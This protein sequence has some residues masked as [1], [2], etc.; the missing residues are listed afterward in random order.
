MI[1]MTNGITASQEFKKQINE[2]IM[3]VFGFSFDRWHALNLWD[4]QYER[5]SIIENGMVIAN[6]SVSKMNMT[7]NGRQRDFLQLGSVATREEYRGKGLSRKI[8]EHIIKRYPETPMF[9]LGNDSVVEFYPKFGFVPITY[10][11]PYLEHKLQNDTKMIKL[12]V[13]DPKVDH[14]LKGRNQFSQ[15]LDCT[16]PYSINWFH[17][18]Y[19][20]SDHIYEIP[21]LD[22]MLIA[23][24]QN[25]TLIIHDLIA[26]NKVTF[27]QIVPHLGFDHVDVIQFGFNP[28][29]LEMDYSM[30][31]YS[32]EDAT[33]FVRGDFGVEKEFII[34]E[35]IIT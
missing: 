34:P 7:I 33:P 32:M 27:A 29:W 2:L 23:E 12:N 14:Y 22:V 31:E 24:Q 21:Q 11:Q 18:L 6:I 16:N 3:H 30:R 25:N 4:D 9:L 15:I 10:K 17:L 26:K 20:H 28:D 5:Y 13:T 1:R 19:G 8:M 35:L